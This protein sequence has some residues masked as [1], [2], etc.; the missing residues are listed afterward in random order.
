MSS[1]VRVPEMGESVVQATVLRWLKQEGEAVSPGEAIVELETDKVSVEVSAETNGVLSRIE[2]K[3]GE[4]VRVGDVLG[5]IETDGVQPA[6]AAPAK[7]KSARAER[8]AAPQEPSE[9]EPAAAPR[10]A[11]KRKAAPPDAEERDAQEAEP[12]PSKPAR[13]RRAEVREEA[14]PAVEG[15]HPPAAAQSVR[16]EPSGAPPPAAKAAAPRTEEE[17][18]EVR[19]RMS[20]RR[21]TIARRL[22][23]AQHTAAM[24]TTFNEIDM[25]RVM[26]IRAKLKERFRE[27]HGVGLGISSFFVKAAVIALKEFPRLNAEVDGEDVVLKRHYDIGVAIGAGEGLVVPVIR[28][29]D[30]LSFAAVER[31]IKA[32]AEK[33]ESGT[34]ELEDLRGGTFTIT[35]GGVYGSLLST[36]IL[37]PPEVGI[38][39]LHKVEE[40]PVAVDGK[41]VIQ[42]RMYVALSY[43]H[44]IVDGREAV[45]FLGRIKSLVEE[46][47]E[48]LLEG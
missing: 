8:T 41:V 18:S 44:R 11:A 43:D 12:P 6:A 25:S 5:F 15:L 46:P 4:D 27:R 31:T 20:A 42:P 7:A 13:K 38:L 39:G 35:N 24:L 3:E 40:R 1:E 36:P 34:L 48:L 33:A 32:F 10:P 9:A 21:R 29:A 16:A 37:N 17:T 30:R 23:E 47:D 19:S 28:A 45:Q 14:V 2:K 26:E 22:V